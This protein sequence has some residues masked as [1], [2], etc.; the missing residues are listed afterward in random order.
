ME[1]WLYHLAVA[2]E[3]LVRLELDRGPLLSVGLVFGAGLATSLT[4][5]TLSMLPLMVGY[6]GAYE[7]RGMI[8][9]AQQSLWFVCGFATTLMGLGLGAVLL[10]RIYGQIGDLW[11]WLL[12]VVAIAMGVQSRWTVAFA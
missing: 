8:A 7:S 9:A 2:A 10:G 5:C 4:P 6:I 12:G 3:Q 11:G 1:Q